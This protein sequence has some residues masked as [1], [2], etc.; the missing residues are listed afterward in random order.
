M[1]HG[2]CDFSLAS[3]PFSSVNDCLL[4]PARGRDEWD[5][6]FARLPAPAIVQAWA[7]GEA[8]AAGGWRVERLVFERGGQPVAICQVLVKRVLGLALAARINRG[9]QFLASRPVADEVR[10]VY[11][12]LRKRWRFGRRGLLV[13]APGLAES[14]EHR[15]WLREAG[16][17]PRRAAG[18]CSAVL[19]LTEDAAVLRR[20]L[21]ST[22][23]T[24]LN[25]AERAGLVFEVSGAEADFEW[26]LARH[27]ENMRD[28]GFAGTSPDF[29]RALWE[30]APA[31]VFVC[32]VLHDGEP[33]AGM[34]VFRFARSA[35]Y[36]VGWFGPEARRK[37]AGNFLMWNALL[38]MQA[39]G[40][41][42]FD[43]GGYS[44]SDGYGRFKQ[45]LRGSEYRLLEEWVAF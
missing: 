5:G 6:L 7:Y 23:R 4:R 36:F 14:D 26:M 43:L 39:R 3:L 44:S 37:K 29:L 13:L 19:D 9:P 21:A 18:W 8:K 33:L 27:Q 38:S 30:R 41:E 1:K 40:C 31:D 15:Q 25:G 28:K 20:R 11:A 22:W 17:I 32:R 2:S 10:A 16:F 45:G 34:L 42:R 35:E 24:Q 12:A